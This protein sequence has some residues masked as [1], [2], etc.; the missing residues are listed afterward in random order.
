MHLIIHRPNNLHLGLCITERKIITSRN[1]PDSFNNSPNCNMDPADRILIYA[2]LLSNLR[3][4]S[5]SCSLPTPSGDS[6]GNTLKENCQLLTVKHAG[7]EA[8][9]RLAAQVNPLYQ[10]APIWPLRTSCI[11]WR[12]PLLPTTLSPSARPPYEEHVIP[13]PASDVEP[14]SHIACRACNTAIVEAGLIKVW[15]DLPSENWAEM[16]EFWH[17]HKPNDH[18][19]DHD[20]DLTSKAYGASSRISAQPGIGFVDLSSFLLSESDISASAVSASLSD[21]SHGYIEGGQTGVLAKQW[22]GH[23]YSYPRL[24]S[25]SVHVRKRRN[26]AFS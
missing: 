15:K 4:I 17:C 20:D 7:L 21:Y 8:S 6:T 16:M 1:N 19:H 14:D 9:V 3:Q 24:I 22:Y 18:G 12:L 10:V 13:W 26:L 11:S 25:S 2:E 5:V 23:R